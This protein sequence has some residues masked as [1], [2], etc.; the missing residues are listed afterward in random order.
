MCAKFKAG[1]R[2][3]PY[4]VVEFDGFPFFSHEDRYDVTQDSN[5]VHSGLGS[6]VAIKSEEY[7]ATFAFQGH[8]AHSQIN[9]IMIGED[10][11]PEPV[12]IKARALDRSRMYELEDAMITTTDGRW[13]DDTYVFEVDV[14]AQDGEII[15]KK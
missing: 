13:R 14:I 6:S 7:S 9:H 2:P 12:D 5:R 4:A 11:V 15:Q 3:S 10:D 8:H 1:G